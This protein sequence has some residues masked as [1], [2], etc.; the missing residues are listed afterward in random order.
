[1]NGMIVG[2]WNYV[3]AAYSLTTFVLLTY[4]VTLEIR[5]RKSGKARAR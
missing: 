1:M 5:A 4:A 3:V 2:G